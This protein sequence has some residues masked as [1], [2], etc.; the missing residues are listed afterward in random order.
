[1]GQES[2]S[3]QRVIKQESE[4]RAQLT[5]AQYAVLREAA[6]E[7]AWSGNLLNVKEDG[8]FD[9]AG[10]G[11]KLFVASDKYDS[12][13]G[14]PSFTQPASDDAISVREDRSHGMVRTEIVCSACGGHLGHV[15]NDGPGPR[16]ERY[17][18]NSLSLNFQPT[19]K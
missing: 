2:Q 11:T 9:C 14:W 17:C 4:W 13:S 12:G 15:F 19:E 18:V 16:G 8:S 1:M 7:P 6:T 10:C 5:P 3:T